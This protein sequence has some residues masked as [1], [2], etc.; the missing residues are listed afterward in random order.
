MAFLEAFVSALGACV[1]NLHSANAAQS[2][3]ALEAVLRFGDEIEAYRTRKRFFKELVTVILAAALIRH[4]RSA[5][6][7]FLQTAIRCGSLLVYRIVETRPL[8]E[9]IIGKIPRPL[10]Y[11]CRIDD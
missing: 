11:A 2:Q 5:C 1:T 6:Y 7:Q 9:R 10:H 8:Y 4:S 3:V